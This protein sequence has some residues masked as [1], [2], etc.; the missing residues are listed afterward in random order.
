MNDREQ[1]AFAAHPDLRRLA[2]LRDQGWHFVHHGDGAGNIEMTT[3]YRIWPDRSKDVLQ[4]LGPGDARGWRSNPDGDTV[5]TRSGGLVEVI[6][7]LL[8]LPP[9]GSPDA[10]RLVVGS[11]R[12]LWI[13]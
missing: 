13:P 7:G 12:R 9:P 11:G 8:E 1:E 6:D 3:G 4:I 2:V 10:P 5:W